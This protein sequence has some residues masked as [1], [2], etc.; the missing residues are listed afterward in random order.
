MSAEIVSFS[1]IRTARMLRQNAPP[2]RAYGF[3]DEMRRAA[4]LQADAAREAF[5]SEVATLLRR[6]RPLYA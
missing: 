6:G 4:Q 1:A 3:V 5:W 2:Q